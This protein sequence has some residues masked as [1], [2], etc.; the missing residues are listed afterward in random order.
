MDAP[1][2][3]LFYVFFEFFVVKKSLLFLR[4]SAPLRET[5]P[6]CYPELSLLPK[7]SP[8]LPLD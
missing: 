5:L 7:A 1:P 8:S 6:R 3:P 4:V 2:F